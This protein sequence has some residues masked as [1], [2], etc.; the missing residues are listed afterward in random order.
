MKIELITRAR[1]NC[2]GDLLEY[3]TKITIDWAD[4]TEEKYLSDIPV[5]VNKIYNPNIF[6]NKSGTLI[7]IK[8]IHPWE[9]IRVVK[10]AA[11][12]I[13]GLESPVKSKNIQLHKDLDNA[14]PGVSIK[15]ESNNSVVNKAINEIKALKEL[16]DT[17]FY[18]FNGLID[19]QGNLIYDYSFNRPDYQDMKRIFSL[20]EELFRFHI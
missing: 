16:L 6:T 4:F 3:E 17:A 1:K 7:K 5:T 15:I 9:N 12:K 10:D 11:I 13:K 8:S 18:K 14:D 20:K 2:E 19:E